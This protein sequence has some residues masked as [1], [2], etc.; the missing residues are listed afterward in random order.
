V[1]S[2]SVEW[3]SGESVWNGAVVRVSVE[4]NSGESVCEVEQW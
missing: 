2:V 4:W 3:S 1:V